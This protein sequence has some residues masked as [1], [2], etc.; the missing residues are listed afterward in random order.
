MKQKP[1]P[2]S[3]SPENQEVLANENLPDV[4]HKQL[5]DLQQEIERIYLDVDQLRKLLQTLVAGLL[6][7]VFLALGISV[8]FAY[9]LLLQEKIAQNKSLEAANTKAEL[10]SEVED[11]QQK[12]QL[13]EQ[14]LKK[15]RQEIPENILVLIEDS[16]KQINQ[17]SDRL[18]KITEDTDQLD[19][20]T[21]EDN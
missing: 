10:I 12:I 19:K 15:M 1:S 4:N 17:L 9:R 7:A 20:S 6:I 14:Q 5:H 21:V 11:L 8:W 18:D 3:N 2:K 13:Q 16:Q